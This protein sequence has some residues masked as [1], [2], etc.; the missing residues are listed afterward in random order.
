LLVYIEMETQLT[1]SFTPQGLAHALN[2]HN[3]PEEYKTRP[4]YIVIGARY[5]L[6]NHIGA[7][8]VDTQ[9]M[10]RD[11]EAL[12]NENLTKDISISF[13]VADVLFT[14]D[15]AIGNRLMEQLREGQYEL[16]P[17]AP[18]AG[19]VPNVVFPRAGRREKETIR[20][21]YEDTQNVHDTKINKSVTKAAK[22][23]YSKYEDIIPRGD[24][25]IRDGFFADMKPEL[26]KISTR[27]DLVDSSIKFMR[28]NVATFGH[29]ITMEDTILAMWLWICDNEHKEELKK[30]LVQELEAM[31]GYCTTGHLARLMNVPQGFTDDPNLQITISIESQAKAVVKSFMTK[32]LSEC[33]D[34]EVIDGILDK[35]EEYKAYLKAAVEAKMEEW[36]EEYG[37]DFT[38]YVNKIAVDFAGVDIFVGKS[39]RRCPMIIWL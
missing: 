18:R 24:K 39:K 7:P 16:P 33:K 29:D 32:T 37:K 36:N 21:V 15:P 31:N 8:R 1:S 3:F 23:L 25:E 30:R 9:K 11:L 5:L 4:R 6:Q 20:T 12:F 13:E 34:D 2:I 19:R 17:V 35:S 26:R 22:Y 38:Q 27:D 10:S 14:H 28:E